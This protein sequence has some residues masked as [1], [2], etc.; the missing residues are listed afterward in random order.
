M[1]VTLVR[2]QIPSV[3]PMAPPFLPDLVGQFDAVWWVALVLAV[4]AFVV[5]FL[6]YRGAIQLRVS[7]EFPLLF[8]GPVAA[9]LAIWALSCGT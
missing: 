1:S 6:P 9:G 5:G 7:S 8:G 3:V 4:I 2:S